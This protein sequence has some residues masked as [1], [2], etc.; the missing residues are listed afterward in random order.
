MSSVKQPNHFLSVIVPAYREELTIVRDIRSIIS[1]LNQIRIRYE[2]IVVVDGFVDKT[3]QRAKKLE[4]LIKNV[5]IVGYKDNR[6]KGYAVR[7]GMAKSS[8]DI[9]AAIDAGMELN[10]NGI[11]MCLEHFEWYNADIIVG[12]KRHPASKVNYNWQRR[13]ISFVYQFI[14]LV[15][16]GLKIRDTQVGL[17]FY[18]RKVL[19][20]VLPRLLVKKYAFD[21]ELLAVAHSLGF[22]RIYEAPIELKFKFKG[23]SVLNRHY[24]AKTVFDVLV[25]TFAVFYRLKILKYY[26]DA[27][28]RKW[29]FDPELIL[30]LMSAKSYE[31]K[32][33]TCF[34]HCHR[35]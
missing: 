31:K 33:P 24:F 19:E 30:G 7:F 23:I 13:I 8:G 6:G 17:K 27:N 4:A 11:S 12:S 25:D 34:G 14:V 1:V 5:R 2:L 16:F 15:L 32:S 26:S 35:F 21:I 22:T 20:K 9:I 29:R 18:R 3:Y 10:P 28:R